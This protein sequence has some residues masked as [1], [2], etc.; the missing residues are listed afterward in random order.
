M[1]LMML[2]PPTSWLVRFMPGISVAAVNCVRPVGTVVSSSWPITRCFAELWTSTTGDSPATV[3]VSWTEPTFISTLTDAANNPLNST[4]PRLTV[5]KPVTENVTWYT[6]G[7]R[8]AI[9]YWPAPSVT[10]DRLF[11]ISVGLAASTVTPGST[12]PEE[13]RTTPTIDAWA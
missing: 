7:R 3:T 5:L 6:P 11:S 2:V 10:T 9:R 13:S 12:A 4:P 8:S 1:T